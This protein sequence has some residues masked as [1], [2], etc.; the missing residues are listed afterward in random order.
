MSRLLIIFALLFSSCG[1]EAVLPPRVDTSAMENAVAALLDARYLALE[2]APESAAAWGQYAIA[3]HAHNLC[4]SAIVCYGRAHALDPTSFRYPYLL[5]HAREQRGEDPERTLEYLE[6]ARAIDSKYPP[7]Y[8]AKGNLMAGAGRLTEAREAFEAALA[9]DPDYGKAHANLG[10]VLILLG[11]PQEA[12]RHLELALKAAPDDRPVNAALSRAFALTGEREKARELAGRTAGLKVRLSDGDS[13]VTEMQKVDTSAEACLQRA[14]QLATEGRWEEVVSNLRVTLKERDDEHAIHSR[15]GHA[16]LSLGRASE[17]GP[18]L[19][20]TLKMNPEHVLARSRLAAAYAAT[21]RK[22]EAKKELATLLAAQPMLGEALTLRG[23]LHLEDNELGAAD[24]MF[25]RARRSPQGVT[26]EG[27]MRWGVALA[28]A[29]RF[30]EAIEALKA[31]TSA[32]PKR[33]DGRYALALALQ[34]NGQFQEAVREYRIA[35]E[36]D[37]KHPLAARARALLQGRR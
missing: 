16:L 28:Q 37:P 3:L 17:A 24:E 23:L 7:L 21:G 14:K 33:A 35:L 6:A 25:R 10:E 8:L 1:Q 30:P 2:S 15:M 13:M 18:Y 12:R 22:D 5:A 4:E 9:Q 26:G 19:E 31:F 34:Q 20:R 36:L 29:S 27:D 32:Q 11:D